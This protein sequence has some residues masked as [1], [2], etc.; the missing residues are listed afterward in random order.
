MNEEK[1]EPQANG[2]KSTVY[3]WAAVLVVL[4]IAFLIVIFQ[5]VGKTNEE[6]NNTQNNSATPTP[7]IERLAA[8]QEANS[9]ANQTFKK[10]TIKFDSLT[11]LGNNKKSNMKLVYNHYPNFVASTLDVAGFS[12]IQLESKEVVFT[13]SIEYQG[14][15]TNFDSDPGAVSLKSEK[16][17]ELYRWQDAKHEDVYRYSETF[18]NNVNGEC[19]N[20][21][22]TDKAPIAC[23]ISWFDFEVEDNNPEVVTKVLYKMNCKLKSGDVADVEWCDQIAKSV[24]LSVI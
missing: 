11:I 14:I 1:A 8:N 19:P 18:S 12:F 15:M 13:V 16:L 24:D 7:T 3:I 5:I 22:G 10:K 6:A 17:P 23:A 21:Y 4:V 2:G 20:Y 9:L